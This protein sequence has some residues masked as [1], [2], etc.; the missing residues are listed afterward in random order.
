[1]LKVTVNL[2]QKL[3]EAELSGFVK[4]EEAVRFAN[5]LKKSLVKFAPQEAYLL[6]NMVGFAPMAND[7]VSILRG[8][9]RDV[10]SYFKKAVL[11]QEFA[12]QMPGRKII[13]PPPGKTL[14][15]YPTREEAI[16]YLF[17]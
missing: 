11:V 17:E 12:L 2:E 15:A 8:V 13:E 6:I 3:V 14:L 1:M 9:G 16:H 4:T 5:E 7:V 10:V